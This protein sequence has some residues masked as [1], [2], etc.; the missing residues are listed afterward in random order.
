MFIL[1]VP[2]TTLS[3]RNVT[4]PLVNGTPFDVN[5][6]VNFVGFPILPL[7]LLTVAIVFV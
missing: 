7:T 3:T 2:A 4:F 1:L 5:F 6:A